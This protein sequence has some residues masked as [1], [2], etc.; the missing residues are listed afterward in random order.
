MFV[1]SCYLAS[2]SKEAWLIDTGC[3]HDASIFKELDQFYTSKVTIGN[4]ECVDVKGKG[5]IAVET[6]SGTKCISDVLFV[7]EVNQNLLSVGQMLERHYALHFEDMKCTIFDSA[8]CELMTI[9]M[10]DKSFLIDWK[11]TA[12]HAFASAVDDFSLWHKRLGHF[13]YSTLKNMSSNDVAQNLPAIQDDA[14]VCDVCQYGKKNKLL[15]PNKA[16][17]KAI[18]KLQLVYT[19]MC[20][21]INI[22]KYFP[23]IY[24]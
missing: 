14:N 3:M 19:D 7:I 21:S 12:M 18:R 15:F 24:R 22:S 11:Q 5:V 16:S 6:P 13:S 23:A 9:K 2:S 4:G 1:A 20:T 10:R 8:S 17:W